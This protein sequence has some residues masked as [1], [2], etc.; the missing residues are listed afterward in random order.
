MAINIYQLQ[1]FVE[2]Y[3]TGS[4]REAGKNLY[5]SYQGISQNIA[6]LEKYLGRPLFIR[7]SNGSA[8]TEFADYLFEKASVILAQIDSFEHD[9]LHYGRNHL[10][11]GFMEG[12]IFSYEIAD[13]LREEMQGEGGQVTAFNISSTEFKAVKDAILSGQADIAWTF[14][15]KDEKDPQLTYIPVK[16]SEIGLVVGAEDPLAQKET[17]SW[18]DLKN[19]GIIL[20]RE[21]DCLSSIF[22]DQCSRFGVE[23]QGLAC[24]AETQIIEKLIREKKAAALMSNTYIRLAFPY[25][26]LVCKKVVPELEVA[27][28]IIYANHTMDSETEEMLE[29]AAEKVGRTTRYW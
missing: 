9:L 6:K 2:V 21:K 24:T 8:P 11:F 26:D 29:K 28:S 4:L 17:V 10:K 3:R 14:H 20:P 13:A 7:D 22:R 18:E 25:D 1:C 27:I 12:L 16:S 23:L 15:R 5:M 19:K